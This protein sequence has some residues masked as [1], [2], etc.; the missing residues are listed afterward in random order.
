MEF[1]SQPHGISNLC[2][3]DNVS[4]DFI[5]TSTKV[6]AIRIWNAAQAQPK[7]MIKVSRHGIISVIPC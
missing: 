1:E 4:G 3:M 6:G 7:E 2:W 5:T